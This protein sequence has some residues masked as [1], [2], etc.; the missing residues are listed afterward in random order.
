M[1]LKSGGSASASTSLSSSSS[2]SK[3]LSLNNQINELLVKHGKCVIKAHDQLSLGALLLELLLNF[4]QSNSFES[5]NH[6]S[7]RKQ[8]QQQ[9]RVFPLNLLFTKQQQNNNECCGGGDDNQ[10]QQQLYYTFLIDLLNSRLINVNEIRNFL[11]QTLL[12]FACEYNN[13]RLCKLLVLH[14]ASFL[15][16]DNYRQTAFVLAAKRN[17][18]KLVKLFSCHLMRRLMRKQ[19]QQQQEAEEI[20]SDESDDDDDEMFDAYKCEERTDSIEINL[21]NECLRQIKRA[22]YHALCLGHL[23]VVKYLFRKFHL[24]SEQ[25]VLNDTAF[26]HIVAQSLNLLEQNAAGDVAASDKS[27][28]NNSSN[29]T[30][31][32][33]LNALHVACYKSNFL[34]VEFLLENLFSKKENLDLFVNRPINEFRDCTPLEEAFKGYLTLDL[35]TSNMMN[36]FDDLNIFDFFESS[37]SSNNNNN[38]RSDD[39]IKTSSVT[40][41][42]QNKKQQRSIR[43]FNRELKKSNFQHIINVLIESGGRF[44]PNFIKNNGLLKLLVQMYCGPKKDVYFLHFLHCCNYLCKFNLNELFEIEQE[45]NSSIS[46][47]SASASTNSMASIILAKSQTQQQ[48]QQQKLFNF[49]VNHQ[50]SLNEQSLNEKYYAETINQQQFDSISSL[51]TTTSSSSSSSS[52][53][54]SN[55]N[56]EQSNNSVDMDRMLEELLHKIYLTSLRVVKDYKMLC[57]TQFIQLLFN[58]HFTGQI[59]LSHYFHRQKLSYLKERNGDILDLIKETIGKPMSLKACCFISIRRSMKKFGIKKIDSLD[60]PRTLKYELFSNTMCTVKQ[61]GFLFNKNNFYYTTI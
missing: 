41:A 11:N 12:H 7:K 17:Y 36:N 59:N 44:S 15:I 48:Q 49:L 22:T 56:N 16:E 6:K 27:T 61:N 13:Y 53:S 54:N 40:T 2:S 25:L 51:S 35:D 3:L 14:D 1:T 28:T 55:S 31:F 10:Q 39:V 52:T 45:S 4:P 21:N 60:M 34:C 23:E 46:S 47:A 33:E 19:Q 50:A 9:H 58:L 30:N 24:N 43:S 42:M 29:D 57:L 5:L 32:A 18:L 8:Q 20:D 37:S 26:I 38:S